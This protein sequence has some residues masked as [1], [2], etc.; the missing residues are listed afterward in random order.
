MQLADRRR[1][2]KPFEGARSEN[3]RLLK[4]K[5]NDQGGSSGLFY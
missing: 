2:D 3:P 5:Q 4:G 1:I